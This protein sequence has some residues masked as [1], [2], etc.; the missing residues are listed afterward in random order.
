[1]LSNKSLGIAGAAMLGTA[2]LLG[3]NAANAIINLDLT[4]KSKAAA[5]YASETLTLHSDGYYVLSGNTAI[6]DTAALDVTGKINLAGTDGSTLVVR[7]DFDGMVLSEAAED[8]DLTIDGHDSISIRTGGAVE[9]DHVVFSASRTA[10]ATRDSLVRLDLAHIGLMPGSFGSVKMTVTDLLGPDAPTSEWIG[11][12][13]AATALDEEAKPAKDQATA[14]VEHRFMSFNGAREAV[15]GSFIVGAKASRLAAGT[16]VQAVVSD[17]IDGADTEAIIITGEFAFAEIVTLN[18]DS[19]CGAVDDGVDLLQRDKAG[20]V[21][22]TEELESLAAT[23]FA[24]QMHL[25]IQVPDSAGDDAVVITPS[26][27]IASTVYKPGT[28]RT[29]FPP[30]GGE[31]ALGS[32][33]R[34]GT[35]VYIDYLTTYEGYNQRIVLSNRSPRDASYSITFRPEAAVTATPM[36]AAEGVL[37]AGSTMTL[38][39]MDVV[40]LEDGNRTAA[41]VIVE[42]N[43]TEVDVATVLVN[44]DSRDTDTV[45]Y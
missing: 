43:T 19:T 10:T 30:V 17:L 31:H 25:C 39:A 18:A 45:I 36:A 33:V 41:T 28:P 29:A 9:D 40:M 16:G 1:M 2:A 11:A 26:D 15:V 22:N 32:I 12:V 42:A 5:T 44:T 34:D 24:T 35:T 8:G 13:R 4:D 37:L 38:R 7:F 6:D 14:T 23:S 20:K 21:S 27:Y 3:T